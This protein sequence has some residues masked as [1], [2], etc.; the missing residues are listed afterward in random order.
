MVQQ[1]RVHI[2]QFVLDLVSKGVRCGLGRIIF[3]DSTSMILSLA[4]FLAFRFRAVL[5][6]GSVGG[7]ARSPVS[8]VWSASLYLIA[9]DFADTMIYVDLGF[10]ICT[11][12]QWVVH[13][14]ESSA[15]SYMTTS[16]NGNFI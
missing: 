2:A 1:N 7:L 8:P 15:A 3:A 11:D 12:E 16:S 4:G 10:S 9:W 13:I 6:V 5:G 14:E